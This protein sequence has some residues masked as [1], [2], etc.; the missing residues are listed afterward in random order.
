MKMIDEKALKDDLKKSAD[1]YREQLEIEVN[2]SLDQIQRLVKYAA[3]VAGGAMISYSVYKTFFESKEVE[4]DESPKKKKSSFFQPIIK[5]GVEITAAYLLSIARQK[6]QE[7]IKDLEESKTSMNG[8]TAG[9][10]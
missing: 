10:N 7:Y 2:E 8:N 5:A 1:S 3:M 9:D 4:K 6:L